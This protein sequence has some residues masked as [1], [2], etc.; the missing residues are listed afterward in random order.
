MN[1]DDITV[2]CK[3]RCNIVDYPVDSLEENKVYT[4]A[5]IN[6]TCATVRLKEL[7]Y[8]YKPFRFSRVV[9]VDKQLR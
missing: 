3:V 2:G 4:V 7:Q 8:W 1:L 5:E 6:Q 9:T